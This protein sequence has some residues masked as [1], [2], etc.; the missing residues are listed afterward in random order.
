MAVTRIAVRASCQLLGIF[1]V[2]LR[3]LKIYI[4]RAQERVILEKKK[5]GAHPVE[6]VRLGKQ[7]RQHER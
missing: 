4:Q 7:N 6:S 5:R 3:E 1:T 2:K